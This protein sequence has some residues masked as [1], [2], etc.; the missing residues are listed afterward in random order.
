[1]DA[2]I[3]LYWPPIVAGFLIGIVAG[4]VAFRPRTKT[5]TKK[6]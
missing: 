5:K 3:A 4:V 1:M 6:D 2:F